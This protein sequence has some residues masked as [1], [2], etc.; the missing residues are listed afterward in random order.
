MT[1]FDFSDRTILVTGSGRNIGRAIILEFAGRGANVVINARSNREEAE[2]VCAE[3]QALAAQALV[4]MGA[5]DEKATIEAIQREVE[6]RFGRLDIYVSNAARRLHKDFFETT[7]EGHR[8]LNQQLTASWYLAKAFAPAMR[9][10]GFGRIIHI[11]GTDGYTGGW[12]RVPHSTAKGGLRTLTKSLAEGLGE[13]GV[14]AN[15]INPGYNETVRDL[16]IHPEFS[17]P[18]AAERFAATIPI[19]RPTRPDEVAFACAFLCSERAGRSTARSS[20]STAAGK[21]WGRPE[22]SG[23]PLRRGYLIRSS[24][25]KRGTQVIL[26]ILDPRFRGDDQCEGRDFATASQGRRPNP[27]VSRAEISQ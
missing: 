5:A 1:E 20:M 12:T 17:E 18:G 26:F 4:V 25:R 2:R 21:C 8:H 13:Y 9:D 22:C 10:A 23:E 27:N 7:D 11:N 16:T 3:A 14:T 19:R 24:A 15:D 6:A